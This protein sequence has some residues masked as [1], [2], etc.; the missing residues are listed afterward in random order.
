MF[1]VD[2]SLRY[3][4]DPA[5][6]IIDGLFVEHP[7]RDCQVDA[8]LRSR[9]LLGP[10]YECCVNDSKAVSTRH[11]RVHRL[12]HRRIYK[13]HRPPSL[14]DYTFSFTASMASPPPNPDTRALPYGWVQQY[15]WESV[16]L[17]TLPD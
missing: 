10:L 2:I 11:N 13:T 15:N 5:Y 4:Q 17:P 12:T 3:V 8:L 7:I 1:F 16:S 14:T 9:P 6:T